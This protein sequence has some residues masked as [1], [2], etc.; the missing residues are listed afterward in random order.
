MRLIKFTDINPMT[1]INRINI[2]LDFSKG[3]HNV[4]LF[5][6]NNNKNVLIEGI[7]EF[8]SNSLDL[9][10]YVIS[11]FNLKP[12]LNLIDNIY[13]MFGVDLELDE[14]SRLEFEK[15][16]NIFNFHLINKEFH[17]LSEIDKFKSMF[18]ATLFSKSDIVLF[19]GICYEIKIN[20]YME[21]I[22]KILDDHKLY[23]NKIFIELKKQVCV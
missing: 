22:N 23:S 11:G 20:K 19:D 1:F 2:E 14:V 7:F 15:Y 8:C 3:S 21:E 12:Y 9:N 13:Y 18:I 10:P 6:R 4:I 5:K 17:F 16:C